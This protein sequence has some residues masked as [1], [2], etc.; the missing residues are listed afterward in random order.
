MEV[1]E[2]EVESAIRAVG[3]LENREN[4]RKAEKPRWTRNDENKYC[5]IINRLKRSTSTQ[6]TDLHATYRKIKPLREALTNSQDQVRA[7]FYISVIQIRVL[8]AFFI[9]T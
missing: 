1:L 5:G 2:E 7:A 6:I 8:F 9:F 3:K 4:D